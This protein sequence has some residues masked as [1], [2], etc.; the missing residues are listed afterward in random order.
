MTED[1]VTHYGTITALTN[2]EVEIY[3]I[4]A[5]EAQWF[6]R[7]IPLITDVLKVR[8]DDPHLPQY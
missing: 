2:E 1:T 6:G 7:R 8:S 4:A 5:E 3:L